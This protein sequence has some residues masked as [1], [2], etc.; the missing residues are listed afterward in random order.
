MFQKELMVADNL[1]P[2]RCLICFFCT[3]RKFRTERFPC[4]RDIS[5]TV[6]SGYGR[7]RSY[8]LFRDN[9]CQV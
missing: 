9:V 4:W 2:E 5:G 1:E 8:Q 6:V 3:D 7:G